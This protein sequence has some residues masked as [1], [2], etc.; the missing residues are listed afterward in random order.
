[1]AMWLCGA[2]GWVRGGGCIGAWVRGC[3]GR[4]IHVTMFV[5]VWERPLPC[6][7]ASQT[8][9]NQP[10]VPIGPGTQP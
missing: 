8:N 10:G 6:T 7:V 3:V 9:K 1:M 4:S 5:L 2:W